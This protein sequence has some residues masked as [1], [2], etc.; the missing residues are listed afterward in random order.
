[1]DRN[2][3]R[4][5]GRYIRGHILPE[6]MSVTQAAQKLGVGRPALSNM[7]NGKAALSADMATR[8]ERVF[9]KST[10]ALMEMQTAYEADMAKNRITAATVKPYTPPFLQI[11]ANHI[12]NWASSLAARSKLAVLIR[13]LVHS[14]GNKLT[15]V[16][17]P[18]GD[19]SERPGR[20]GYTEAGE[21]NPWIPKGKSG[22]E[23]SVCRNP[24]AKADKDYA[25]SITQSSE[26][27]RKETTFIFVTPRRWPN[28]VDWENERCKEKK[29][30]DVRV[31][32]VGNLE[33]WLEQSIPGQ[34]WFAG[35]TG[36]SLDGV[37][38]LE[39]CWRE[40]KADCEP[41]LSPEL[42]TPAIKELRLSAKEKLLN[43]PGSPLTVSADSALEAL[44]F[45]YCMFLKGV[46]PE[47]SHLRD[48]VLVL[49]K[50]DRLAKLISKSSDF[51]S[52]T[53]N[54]QVERELAQHVKN[55][56]SIIIY[57]KNAAN[58]HPDIALEPLH[59]ESFDNALRAMGCNA[60]E[61][62]RFSRESGKS[63]TVLRRRLSNIAAVRTPDWVSDQMAAKSLVPFLFAGA[64]ETKNDADQAVMELLSDRWSYRELEGQFTSLCQFED[65]LAWSAGP[66]R[67]LVS[68]IDVLFAIGKIITD[69]DIRRF[70][71]VAQLVLSEDDPSLDL[72][73]DR[74]WAAAFYGKRRDVSSTLRD[75]ICETLVILSVYGNQL[76]KER[77]NIDL[78]I[79][80]GSL[81]REL[82]TPLTL[83]TLEA[84]SGDFPV[85]AEAAPEAF[86]DVLEKDLESDM[87]LSFGLMRPVSDALFGRC[88]HTGLLWA[89]ESLAWSEKYLS[90]VVLILGRLSQQNIEDN[91]V[92]RPE[93][94]LNSIF[95]CWMPQTSVGVEKRIAV[96]ELL[97]KEFPDV[98]WKIGVE[99]FYSSHGTGDYSYKPRW[100]TD[101]HGHGEPVPHGEARKFARHALDAAM[102]W[103]H[104][105]RQTL[106]DLVQCVYGLNEEYQSQIWN[107]IEQWSKSAQE[108]DKSWMREKIRRSAFIRRVEVRKQ[109]ERRKQTDSSRAKEVYELLTPSGV[110]LKHEWLF[111][112]H[113]VEESIEE[114]EEEEPDLHKQEERIA[115]MREAALREILQYRGKHGLMEI[116]ERGE[117]AYIIGRLVTK[118]YKTSEDLMEV[119][120]FV[121][122]YGSFA[123]EP[124]HRSLVCA[125]LCSLP[126]DGA[127]N[128][129]SELIGSLQESERVPVL[130]LCPFDNRTWKELGKL[131][132]ET[133]K[134]YWQT[135]EPAIGVR[136]SG[137][138]LKYAVDKLIEARRPR[139]AFSLIRFCMGKV[140]AKQL[141]ELLFAAGNK[142]KDSESASVQKPDPYAIREALE[143]LGERG[144]ID[145]G[146]LAVLEFKYIDA[147]DMKDGKIPN[148]E[149]QIERHPE[150]YIQAVAFAYKRSDKGDDPEELEAMDENHKKTR[151]IKAYKMLGKLARVPG[152]DK[153]GKQNS[154]EM[155]NWVRQV[156]AGCKKLARE[157][158]CDLALGKLFSTAPEGEDGIWPGHPVRDALE[159]CLNEEMSESLMVAISNKRGAHFRGKGGDQ[160]RQIAERFR[161]QV[162]ALQYT[163]TKIARV[164]NRL[165]ETYEHEA[166]WRDA[167]DVA[168]KR[169]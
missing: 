101:G 69:S 103:K 161:K 77:L 51:I 75:G 70:L 14:T 130:T 4:H 2:I 131:D 152:R 49:D 124:S 85:Y 29:W 120:R 94:S 76:F 145:V 63:L 126:E 32:D 167:E 58:I 138:D 92:N 54:R 81:V 121:L 43:P 6:G 169:L 52:V 113:W 10:Q 53:A 88:Y 86:L 67:G 44:A 55:L 127:E 50:P 35:E 61:I 78:E 155:V 125:V 97:S 136:N 11:R 111:L 147:L 142:E 164:L 65:A 57:P 135:V 62:N 137:D 26:E 34:I 13:T 23:F 8:I 36:V 37:R 42:F 41:D 141:M 153:D 1:M 158:G 45:L 99:Q 83:R 93:H 162:D 144:E 21:A 72:P 114:I 100:R 12:E 108:E 60:D 106:A 9:G 33:E 133:Q 71:K 22:W 28:K 168:G 159:Q 148:L 64:W 143:T 118:I 123:D 156:R 16:E 7:L 80:T 95:R 27:E 122:D 89:L 59:H 160:E 79:E 68:K 73:E 166:D 157:R 30:K 115:N 98:A 3:P 165:A 128:A 74:R 5:P 56:H 132:G 46:V 19:D 150:L 117:A 163:H 139:S 82:L 146:D 48:S 20:D 129:L 87:P 134:N 39:A 107:L 102:N 24:K 119:I 15:K 40:W 112:N 105:N 149:I 17:F 104:H 91:W 66:Y 151:A 96:F 84:Q 47:L 38:S 25:K 140:Q 18:G 109:K 110:I 116:A 90:R 31:Y 154:D